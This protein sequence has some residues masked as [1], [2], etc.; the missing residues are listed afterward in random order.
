MTQ[1]QMHQFI[2]IDHPLT[3]DSVEVFFN[4]KTNNFGYFTGQKEDMN[5]LN[6]WRFVPN[7]TATKYRDTLSNEF[8]IIIDGD[9]VLKLILL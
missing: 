8:T 2:R 7:V 9:E 4:D 6:K 3:Y 5:D 1:E